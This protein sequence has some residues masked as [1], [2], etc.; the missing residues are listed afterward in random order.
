M[1]VLTS[2]SL[3]EILQ[4]A[5]LNTLLGMGV[6]FTVLIL[7]SLL[8][9]SMRFIPALLDMLTGKGKKADETVPAV[10]GGDGPTAVI[11]AGEK[12]EKRDAVPVAAAEEADLALIAVITAAVAAAANVPEDGIVIRSIR[13]SAKNNWKRA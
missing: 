6:V 8:I 10:A 3:G 7:I 11:R 4:K 9:Y 5:G 1:I 13:R 12:E 2:L